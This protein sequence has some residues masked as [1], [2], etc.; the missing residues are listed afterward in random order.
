MFLSSKT[1][2]ILTLF[3]D[4]IVGI[5]YRALLV[6]GKHSEKYHQPFFLFV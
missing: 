6:L 3:S 1:L 2:H 5:K 4:E